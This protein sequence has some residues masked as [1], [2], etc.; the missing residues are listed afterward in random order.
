MLTSYR[1]S[2]RSNRFSLARLLVRPAWPPWPPSF[3]VPTQ[4]ST[5]SAPAEWGLSVQ[6]I[7]AVGT[8]QRKTDYFLAVRAQGR[9]RNVL[10]V[11]MRWQATLSTGLGGSTA[12]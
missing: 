2:S 4:A 5:A 12:I 3:V 7:H 1:H 6:G 9:Q 8:S 11:R 10:S